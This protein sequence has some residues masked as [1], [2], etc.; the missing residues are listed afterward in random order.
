MEWLNELKIGDAVLVVRNTQS[1]LKSVDKVTQNFIIV[2]T[3][4]YRKEDGYRAGDHS[5]FYRTH[6]KQATEEEMNKILLN[7]R[8]NFLN[9]FNF[10][11]LPE[12][13]INDIY[14]EIIDL[15]KEN[16]NV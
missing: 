11:K 13:M 6:L 15:R 3:F 14:E 9:E 16:K 4:K 10:S 1:I 12:K 5:T 2:D 7:K 8:I